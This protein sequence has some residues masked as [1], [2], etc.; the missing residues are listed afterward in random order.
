MH[1]FLFDLMIHHVAAGQ[2]GEDILG[3]DAHFHH[4]HHDV[5]G[6]IG[7]FKDGFF[8][9][10]ALSS[11]DDLGAFLAHFF[12]NLIDALLEQLGGV[13]ALLGVGFTAH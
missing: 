8:L 11:H 5:I 3:L 4:E 12:Q 1:L 6:Q 10:S 9:A 7:D 2:L 13:A